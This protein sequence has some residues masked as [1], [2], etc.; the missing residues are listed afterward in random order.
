MTVRLLGLNCSPRDNSNSAIMLE[1]GFE[2]L[3]AMYPGEC[4][5][6]VVHLRDLH[7]EPCKACA[8]CGKKKDG[9]FIPCVREH[10]DD[11]QGVLDAMVAAD[12][13]LV[14]T[15]VYFGLPSDLFSKFIMRTRPL[16]HQDFKLANKPLGVLATAGRRSGGAE[17]AIIATWLPFVRNGCLVVGNG[18]GTSPVRRLRLG[19]RQGPHRSA[20]SG[21]SSRPSRPPS[22]CSRSPASS[23]PAPR[24]PATRTTCASRTRRAPVPDAPASHRKDRHMSDADTILE[25]IRDEADLE[26]EE[27]TPDTSLFRDQLLDSMNL[28][29]LIAF[30]E[31]EFAIKVKPMD[32]VYEN[33]DTVNHMLAYVARKKAG[34]A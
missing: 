22:A 18:D 26:D 3:D 16:R 24:P 25:F 1:H 17:T 32:I 31:E 29:A 6:D 4:E 15:P 11:V 19:R 33:L 7:I 28:T 27:V 20:T 13:L 2:K 21:A 8:V 34:D 10:E 5:H 12:G 23:R 14:A 9:T 30:L